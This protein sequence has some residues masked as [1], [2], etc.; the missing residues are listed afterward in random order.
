MEPPARRHGW[1]HTSSWVQRRAST[2]STRSETKARKSTSVTRIPI[3]GPIGRVTRN[4]TPLEDT[5]L[6]RPS[7]MS[8]PASTYPHPTPFVT[9]V[10]Y[11]SI[12]NS[13]M[14]ENQRPAD[15]T[16]L[17][18]PRQG[19][20][21][22]SR[23]FSVLS[24]I[25]NSLSRASLIHH[26]STS[27][28]DSSSSSQP[29]VTPPVIAIPRKQPPVATR[30]SMEPLLNDSQCQK[31]PCQ[32]AS[33]PL[34]DNP[35]FVT[36]A[37]PSQ[38]W[39]GRFAALDDKFHNEVLLGR[40][41]NMVV[42]A[43]TNRSGNAGT[44]SSNSAARAQNNPSASA[45]SLIRPVP[46][47]AGL[48]RYNQG[49]PSRQTTSHEHSFQGPVSR[50]PQSA[51]SGAILQTTP[52]STRTREQQQPP[53]SAASTRTAAYYH[54]P[55]FSRPP[56]YEQSVGL[57]G[58]A[59]APVSPIFEGSSD[60]LDSVVPALPPTL[61]FPGPKR[62]HLSGVHVQGYASSLSSEDGSVVTV[63]GDYYTQGRGVVVNN[64]AMLTDDDAR[65][66]R[67]LVHLEAMCVTET[68][69]ESLR[70]WRIAYARK[71]G[72]AVLL[73]CGETMEGACG[74]GRAER[75]RE[76]QHLVYG[77]GKGREIVKRLRRSLGGVTGSGGGGSGYCH[78]HHVNAYD[79]EVPRRRGGMMMG[80]M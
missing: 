22:K 47:L 62:S 53:G 70:A 45:Y 21:T 9:T 58:T 34:P 42:E 48:A 12:D 55:L 75:E 18:P 38:Y 43:Q 35:R 1:T 11:H 7:D 67:V 46:Q 39:S 66:R 65:R 15:N 2:K 57:S 72:R 36:T 28:N 76:R 79:E 64:A 77:L 25:T 41:L 71:T 37:M 69:R 32:E 26:G 14:T 33:P 40:N 44:G 10:D 13:R 3:S 17:P 50:I 61:G 6:M 19:L 73:P 74:R 31:P 56:S 23:T 60:S 24:S 51:T 54:K 29:R 49:L 30:C 5:N 4:G 63:E 80:M 78:A 27:R 20:L 52:Y 59:T 68:A 8:K 16:S